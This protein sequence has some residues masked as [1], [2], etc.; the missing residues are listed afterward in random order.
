MIYIGQVL[1]KLIQSI[2]HKFT[3]IQWKLEF[4]IKKFK[5]YKNDKNK[6]FNICCKYNSDIYMKKKKTYNLNAIF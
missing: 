5:T 1:Q 2:N 4:K 6:I 3:Q